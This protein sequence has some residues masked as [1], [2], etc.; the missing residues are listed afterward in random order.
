MTYSSFDFEPTD[1]TSDIVC[2]V[3]DATLF[4]CAADGNKPQ[5]LFP[6]TKNVCVTLKKNTLTVRQTKRRIN[7]RKQLITI[8][9]PTHTVPNITISSEKGCVCV[10]DGIFGDFNLSM[11]VGKLTIKGCSFSSLYATCAD[12]RT[13]VTDTTFKKSVNVH[14]ARG[15]L[16]MENTF[17]FAASCRIENGNIGLIDLCG[18]TFAFATQKGNVTLTLNGSESDYN[19]T[20]KVKDGTTNKQKIINDGAQKSISVI[21]DEGNVML[22][23]AD[24]K[25]EIEEAAVALEQNA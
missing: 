6:E 4:I 9:V 20:V 21:V 1:E 24:E 7:R 3:Y 18:N 16:L 25:T 22:N 2:D 23:F 12:C 13:F 15:Q 10:A 14:I 8:F 5:I 19:A 17:A 11:G